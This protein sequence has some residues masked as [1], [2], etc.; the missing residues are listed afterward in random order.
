MRD[1]IRY[2]YVCTKGTEVPV[3]YTQRDE[4]ASCTSAAA[5]NESEVNSDHVLLLVLQRRG[6]FVV[7]NE[8]KKKNLLTLNWAH[9]LFTIHLPE[10]RQ[11]DAGARRLGVNWRRQFDVSQN[12]DFLL[13]PPPPPHTHIHTNTKNTQTHTNIHKRTHTRGPQCLLQSLLS[14]EGGN[15]SSLNP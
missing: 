14:T 1:S 11:F 10:E 13:G 6:N 5:N 7:I 12:P 3:S 2:T 8:L 15:N 4:D 9:A